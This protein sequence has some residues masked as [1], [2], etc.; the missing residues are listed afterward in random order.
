MINFYY[1][2]AIVWGLVFILYSF[3]WSNFNAPLNAGLLAFLIVTIALSLFMGTIN[4]ERF[5]YHN[6]IVEDHKQS[7]TLWVVL[8]FFLD[9]LYAR[10][11]P[12]I[13]IVLLHS[14][15]Y[16]DFTG[17]PTFHVII[18]AIGAIYAIY[19]FQLAL[20]EENIKTRKQY[21][22]EFITV[23]CLFLLMFYRG[24][25]IMVGF[26]C[27]ASFLASRSQQLFNTK[28][29]I[30]AIIV[31][32]IALYIFGILGN[33]R[34]GFKWN[35][36]SSITRMGRYND[37]YPSF[38]P[39]QYMW[40]YSYIT[41]PLA[42]LNNYI[43]SNSHNFDFKN[44]IFSVLPDFLTKRVLNRTTTLSREL[45]SL[46][47]EYFNA[48]TG[49]IEAYYY[50]GIAGMYFYYFLL[51]LYAE[52]ICRLLK[53]SDY[54]VLAIVIFDLLLGFTFFNNTLTLSA[55]SIQPIII[56]IYG[57]LKKN[58]VCITFKGKVLWK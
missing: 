42:N 21:I 47:A 57:L 55:L 9:F 49:Y 3:G 48:S 36:V 39:K 23:N 34:S 22:I 28:N 15:N 10:Q 52:I 17:I 19:L 56:L 27:L 26:C 25:L 2:Y 11:I 46:S 8:L 5:K 12:F 29:I 51:V 40:S 35:D 54:Q 58:N 16:S 7:S 14:A 44:Y 45:Y 50:G 37:S 13:S 53:K 24:M 41:S 32:I 1:V 31:V 38:I 33:I 6:L 18:V 30:I 4:R 20:S 43:I